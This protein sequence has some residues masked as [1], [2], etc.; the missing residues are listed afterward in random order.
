MTW[1]MKYRVMRLSSRPERRGIPSKRARSRRT[2]GRRTMS[3]E[4]K[5]AGSTPW[6]RP[7]TV[8]GSLHSQ[9][10]QLYVSHRL[11]TFDT[12]PMKATIEN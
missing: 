2:I 12:A 10:S 1:K 4:S 6:M 9:A 5:A 11:D 7:M 3:K 8:V